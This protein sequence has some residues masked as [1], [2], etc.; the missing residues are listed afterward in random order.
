MLKRSFVLNE[1]DIAEA[2]KDFV[3]KKAEISSDDSGSWNISFICNSQ[4]VRVEYISNDSP[5]E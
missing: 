3:T 2:I 1:D 4:I 5:G